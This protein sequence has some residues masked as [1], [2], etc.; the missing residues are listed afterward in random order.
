MTIPLSMKAVPTEHPEGERAYP[1]RPAAS[2]SR[3]VGWLSGA[4]VV[5][6]FLFQG[7]GVSLAAVN[8]RYQLNTDAVAYLQIASYYA[9]RNYE[10]AL[11]GYWGPLLSWLLAPLLA[12]GMNPL[13][14]GRLLMGL[15]AFVF[16]TGC[17]AVLRAMQLHPVVLVVGLWLAVARSVEWSAILITPDLLLAG[18]VTWAVAL[19]LKPTWLERKSTQIFAGL[20]FGVAFYAKAIGLPMGVLLV[21]CF[22]GLYSW[23]RPGNLAVLCRAGVVSLLVLACLAAP[24]IVLLSTKYHRLLFS[25]S[26]IINHALLHPEPGSTEYPT[27]AIG[28]PEPGRISRW[29]DPLPEQYRTWSPL[30]NQRYF[31]HQFKMVYKNGKSLVGNLNSMDYLQVGLGGLVA[32][33]LLFWCSRQQAEA[34]RWRWTPFPVLCNVLF[35]LPVHADE[36]RFLYPSYPFLFVAALGLIRFPLKELSRRMWVW[37]T[38]IVV[39]SFVLPALRGLDILLPYSA[40]KPIPSYYT[41]AEQMRGAR[42]SGSIV[43][44]SP[45]CRFLAFLLQQP[46]YGS[47]TDPDELL[48][49]SARLIVVDRDSPQAQRFQQERTLTDLDPLLFE[50]PEEARRCDLKVFE[51]SAL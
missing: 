2:V 19:L 28:P 29:E 48:H 30:E 49:A 42:I 18:L 5:A 4:A 24:W 25:T 23:C 36:E 11:S 50:D 13:T 51:R 7:L 3:H 39:F 45:H 43:G 9:T 40:T 20:L 32:T 37:G 33:F 47:S 26:A 1:G 46:C 35:Y 10:L 38:V 22:V 8:N 17:W 27:L 14:A 15:S 6:A 31:L 16:S 34:E 41:L 12:L 21:V 44:D